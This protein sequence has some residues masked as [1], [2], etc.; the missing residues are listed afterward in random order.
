MGVTQKEKLRWGMGYVYRYAVVYI[1]R[2]MFRKVDNM[3]R[4]CLLHGGVTGC[5]TAMTSWREV[6]FC[7]DE[8][9]KK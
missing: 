8:E 6:W 3:R 2:V 5:L 9:C 4:I 7:S 1:L